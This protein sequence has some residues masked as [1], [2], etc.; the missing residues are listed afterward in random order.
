MKEL[1]G[2]VKGSAIAQAPGNKKGERST[3]GRSINATKG[4][5]TKGKEAELAVASEEE[6]L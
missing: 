5:S 6:L 1:W 4:R 2:L 3:K